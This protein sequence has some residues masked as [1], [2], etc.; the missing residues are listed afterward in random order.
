MG[1]GREVRSSTLILRFLEK[2][3]GNKKS[4]VVRSRLFS[5]SRE[6]KRSK[7]KG[8]DRINGTPEWRMRV[9]AFDASPCDQKKEKRKDQIS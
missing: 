1:E 5:Y 8:E 4:G 9:N 7:K 2:G 3:E 6:E